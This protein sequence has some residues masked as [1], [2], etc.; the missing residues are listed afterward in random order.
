MAKRKKG[1]HQFQKNR[2]GDGVT[3]DVIG[4]L[5]SYLNGKQSL[6]ILSFS[7]NKRITKKSRPLLINI[8]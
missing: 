6:K 3:D 5:S 1:K 8:I 7:S 4:M 2:I